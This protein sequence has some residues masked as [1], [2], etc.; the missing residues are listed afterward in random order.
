MSS[1]FSDWKIPDPGYRA[2]MV[3]PPAQTIPGTPYWHYGPGELEACLL[4]RMKDVVKAEKL[5]VGYPGVFQEPSREA[6][7]LLEDKKDAAVE[8][9]VHGDAEI[10]F[11]GK[12][13]DSKPGDDGNREIV[14]PENGVLEVRLT[15]SEGDVPALGSSR[16]WKFRRAGDPATEADIHDRTCSGAPP[17]LL[18]IPEFEVPFERRNDGSFDTGCEIFGFVEA[19][20]SSDPDLAVGESEEEM[21]NDDPVANEQSPAM[22]EIGPGRYRSIYPLTFRY[23]RFRNP[24]VGKVRIFATESPQCYCGAFASGERLTRMWGTAAYTLRL[25]M[26]EF[27]I[28]GVKRDRLPWGGDF[29]VSLLAD[30]YVFHDPAVIRRTL[31]VLGA[32]GPENGDVNTIVDY[33]LW[34][35]VCHDLYQ[36]YFADREFLSRRYPLIRRWVDSF[37][38]RCDK[39][40]FLTREIKWLFIDWTREH[41]DV[42]LQMIYYR[43]LCAAERL[44]VRAGEPADA[45]RWGEAARSL[46]DSIQAK[47]WDA[48][49]KLFRTMIGD[50]GAPLTRQPNLLA[51]ALGVADATQAAAIVE[52]LSGKELAPVGTPY[53]S[54]FEAIACARGGCAPFQSVLETVWGSMMDFGATTFWEAYDPNTP[55]ESRFRFYKREFGLSLCHAWSAGPAFLL[56]MVMLGLRPLA[57]G[58]KEFECVPLVGIPD[59]SCTVPTPH[60]PIHAEFHNGTLTV[61]H[62][63]TIERIR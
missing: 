44:A 4:K 9:R 55:P 61:H 31:T 18:E 46:A 49:R 48:K 34:L 25:C 10:R 38:A 7:F 13:V 43:A 33:S 16:R 26:R 1:S 51:V 3:Y 42:A 54:A 57:D 40:G 21:R 28:D 29:A 30:A 8:F 63:D 12:P 17:H 32:A 59:V 6:V 2:G 5:Y 47:L 27:L 23:F 20:S 45:T 58:W 53:V 56:P 11:N 62:P 39:D 22:R 50:P 41:S 15:V 19:A 14:F 24:E 36:L 60:G 52:E 37:A 35:I